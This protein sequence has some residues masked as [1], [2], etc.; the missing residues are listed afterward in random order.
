M[1]R[2]VIHCKVQDDYTGSDEVRVSLDGYEIGRVSI[3]ER[4]ILEG[5]AYDHVERPGGWEVHAG[6]RLLIEEL[7]LADANDVL[8]DHTFTEDDFAHGS[9]TG[10]TWAHGM[11]DFGV[12]L[13]YEPAH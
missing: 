5:T 13:R 10:G 2:V 4:A 3:K 7:D 1:E 9:V 6:S 12:H 11:Y 8:W